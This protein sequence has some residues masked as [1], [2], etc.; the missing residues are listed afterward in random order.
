MTSQ[1]QLRYHVP[2]MPSQRDKHNRVCTEDGFTLH[3][4]GV[5]VILDLFVI[6]GMIRIAATGFV[7]SRHI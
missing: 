2:A 6:G 4:V 5:D 1:T 3:C 7:S